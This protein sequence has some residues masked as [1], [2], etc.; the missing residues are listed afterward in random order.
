MAYPFGFLARFFSFSN[1]TCLR[2]CLLR[3]LVSSRLMDGDS[4]C[5]LAGTCKS[6]R[7]SGNQ[8]ERE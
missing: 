4:F 1:D 2:A 5:G 3:V 6:V 8:S 7:A